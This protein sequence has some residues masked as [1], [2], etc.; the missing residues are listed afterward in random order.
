MT[1]LIL[2]SQDDVTADLVV[3][4][5]T[6]TG[7]EVHRVALDDELTISGI[8]GKRIIVKDA[9]RTTI[10]PQGIYWRRPGP[11]DSE[12]AKA[13]VGMLR[14]LPGLVWVNHPD[15]NEKARHKPSQL[16]AARECGFNVPCTMIGNDVDEI[17]AF[18]QNYPDHV[19]KPLHQGETFVPLGQGMIYQQRIRKRSD[20]RLTVVGKRLFP[21]RITSVL[22]DWRQDENANY[23]PAS[24]PR[25]IVNAVHRYMKHFGL[26]FGAFD[27]AVA[28][29][30]SWHFLE[31]NPNGQFGFVE[32]LCGLGISRALADL[33]TEGPGFSGA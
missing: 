13:L 19:I 20:I 1:V 18:T 2:T 25:E 22:E 11:V 23:E 26:H 14:A 27:F 8:P 5:C 28:E 29:D 16:V 4:Q 3:R 12:Q 33:L 31:C 32:K 24:A 6:E 17:H 7:R 30:G 9:H 21:C 15:H 10:S